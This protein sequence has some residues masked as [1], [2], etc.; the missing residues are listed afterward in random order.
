[1]LKKFRIALLL[2]WILGLSACAG[3]PTLAPIVTQTPLPEIASPTPTQSPIIVTPTGAPSS[4]VTPTENVAPTL[5]TSGAGLPDISAANYLDDRST[6][7]AV[8]LS[9][10]N[11]INKHEYLRAYSYYTN[12]TD[13]GTLDQFTAGYETTQSVAVVIGEI[14][15]EGAAG[16]LYYTVPMVLNVTNTANAAQKYAACYVVRLPQPGNYGEPPITPM[17]IERGTAKSIAAGTA[18]ADALAS[19]CPEPDYPTGPGAAP[20]Q[21]ESLTD[22]S[23]QNYID[24]RSDPVAVLSSLFN[25]VNRKEYVRAYSY[26]QTPPKDYAAFAAG[27]ANTE[28]VKLQFG[29][30]TPDAGAGQIYYALPVAMKATLTDG[31]SQTFVACY[32]LHLAQPGIQGTLPFAPLGIKSATV[33]QVDNSTDVTPLLATACQ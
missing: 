7:A 12:F 20:A 32:T 22:L 19:A 17:H 13:L 16:S 21:L 5:E 24:N 25:A 29:T 1:M 11:A 15:G 33:K 30:A 3:Q 26:W 23:S 6:P 4:A 9:F 14:S 2:G 18:D 28:T 8:M 31:K 10:F 27:Y